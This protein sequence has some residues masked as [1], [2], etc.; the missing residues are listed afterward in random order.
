M[1]IHI[2]SHFINRDRVLRG[3]NRLLESPRKSVMCIRAPEHMGKSWLMHKMQHHCQQPEVNLPVAR[4]EFRDPLDLDR[5]TDH[6]GLIRL[7]RDRFEQPAA[8]SLLNHTINALT[9]TAAGGTR[10]TRG[11]NKLATLAEQ[12][13]TVYNLSDLRQFTRFVEVEFENISGDTL[14]DKAYGLVAHFQQRNATTALLEHLVADRP[15]IQWQPYFNELPTVTGTFVHNN[16]RVTN[17]PR[18]ESNQADGTQQDRF[19]QDLDLLLPTYGNETERRHIERQISNAFFDCIS[20]LI[21]QHGRVMLLID[22]YEEIPAVANTFLMDQLFPRLLA[23]PLDKLVVIIAGREVPDIPDLALRNKTVTT[24]LTNFNE[25][26]IIEFMQSRN[27]PKDDSK[28]TPQSALT[29]SGGAPGILALMA[30]RALAR[31][32]DDEDDFFD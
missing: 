25:K 17:M 6:L 4:V 18:A 27:V 5:I 13:E 30:D 1:T 10:S 24:G 8:F 19:V 15:N 23:A 9:T 32:N 22:A 20:A 31:L 2:I 28:W 26:Y 14:H 29:F 11:T 12:I 21:E 7:L 3:F 16:G